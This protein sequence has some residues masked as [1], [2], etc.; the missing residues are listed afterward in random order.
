MYC[1]K[2]LCSTLKGQNSPKRTTMESWKEDVVRTNALFEAYG[3]EG[4]ADEIDGLLDGTLSHIGW[5]MTKADC[6]DHCTGK[7]NK[8]V[9][10]QILAK[11]GVEDN[12]YFEKKV[13]ESL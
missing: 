7:P 13:G 5:C 8:A 6:W 1:T 2:Y 9:Y 3:L 11:Y 10:K 12:G 4:S